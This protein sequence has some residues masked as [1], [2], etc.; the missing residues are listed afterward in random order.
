MARRLFAQ[1]GKKKAKKMDF[2]VQKFQEETAFSSLGLS[3][4]EGKKRNVF[5]AKYPEIF[6]SSRV[7]K[8][9]Q[10]V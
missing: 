2:I 8:S 5:N 7:Y 6:I 4:S 3:N 10:C 1:V 9:E